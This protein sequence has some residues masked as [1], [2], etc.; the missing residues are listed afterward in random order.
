MKSKTF[1]FKGDDSSIEIAER[2]FWTSGDMEIIGGFARSSL[3]SKGMTFFVLSEN[4]N[5]E[6]LIDYHLY[7]PLVPQH[8]MFREPVSYLR[9]T[10]EFQ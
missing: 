9:K 6:C 7:E 2:D 10:R 3:L 1:D 8:V 4:E 5:E